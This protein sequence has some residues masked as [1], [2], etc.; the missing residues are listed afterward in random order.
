MFT[1]SIIN[2]RLINKELS[3]FVN[4]KNRAKEFVIKPRINPNNIKKH[5]LNIFLVEGL[6][7]HNLKSDIE[8]NIHPVYI[9]INK[10]DKNTI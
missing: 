9:V 5:I 8:N 2:I 6:E 7:K 1:L 10:Q 4:S 3:S